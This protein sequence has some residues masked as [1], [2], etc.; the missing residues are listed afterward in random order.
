MRKLHQNIFYYYTGASKNEKDVE[1]QIEDNTTKAFINT[2]ENCSL[3]VQKQIIENLGIKIP[4]TC[5]KL[6]YT[7]QAST[8]GCERI[9]KRKFIL[10]ISPSGKKPPDYNDKDYRNKSRPDAWIWSSSPSSFVILLENKTKGE[11]DNA[12][13]KQHGKSLGTGHELIVKKWI[14]VHS[15]IKK[16]SNTELNKTDKFILGEFKRYLEVTNLSG[17]DGF[18]K[19]DFMRLYSDDKA[20][21]DYLVKKF[22]NLGMAIGKR[23]DKERHLKTKECKPNFEDKNKERSV[24][25]FGFYDNTK[26]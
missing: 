19:E 8:I 22:K 1:R 14:D 2:L 10:A 7:L 25:W 15:A 21:F 5:K 24:G 13:L 4:K 20:E 18:D 17:F 26:Y 12:Q 16:L 6:N 3:E 11:L 9:A 23:L